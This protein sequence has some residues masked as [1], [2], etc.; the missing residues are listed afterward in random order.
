[1]M[2]ALETTA[3]LAPEPGAARGVPSGHVRLSFR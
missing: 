1:M 2:D 3:W